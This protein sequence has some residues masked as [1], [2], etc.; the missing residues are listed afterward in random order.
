MIYRIWFRTV[1]V[2]ICSAVFNLF[3]SWCD[4]FSWW[5]V[6]HFGLGK[7]N[8]SLCPGPSEASCCQ[9]LK[10]LWK[11]NKICNII[12]VALLAMWYSDVI[13]SSKSEF[14]WKL[15]F[16]QRIV[17]GHFVAFCPK[18]RDPGVLDVM[19][20]FQ[21]ACSPPLHWTESSYHFLPAY[22]VVPRDLKLPSREK[23]TIVNSL[24]HYL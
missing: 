3:S 13:A 12:C 14:V 20:S 11:A 23:R 18:F 15:S 2:T 4:Y 5:V 21:M 19:C 1:S 22:G 16:T 8:I 24:L 17:L 6:V 9:F 7:T 10:Q